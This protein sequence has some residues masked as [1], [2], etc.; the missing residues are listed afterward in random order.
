MLSKVHSPMFMVK[1]LVNHLINI[2]RHVTSQKIHV[3]AWNFEYEM[4][5]QGVK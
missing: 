4:D 1:I 5:A 3:K 2:H